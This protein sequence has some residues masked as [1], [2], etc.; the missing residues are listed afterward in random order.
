MTVLE[1]N[2]LNLINKHYVETEG[3]AT[4]PCLGRNIAYCYMREWDEQ[5]MMAAK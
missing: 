4:E 1:N 3:G 5:L 2:N